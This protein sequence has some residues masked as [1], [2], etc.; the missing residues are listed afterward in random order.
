M[1]CCYPRWKF[2]EISKHGTACT[3]LQDSFAV[4]SIDGRKYYFLEDLAQIHVGL[5]LS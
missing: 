3:D 4:A 1:L 2:P 5:T